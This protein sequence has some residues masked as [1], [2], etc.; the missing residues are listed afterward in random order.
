MLSLQLHN[1]PAT[2]QTWEFSDCCRFT[3]MFMDKYRIIKRLVHPIVH[4]RRIPKQMQNTGWM[5]ESSQFQSLSL[6]L[7]W[8]TKEELWRTVNS[9]M[10]V[11]LLKTPLHLPPLTSIKG[12]LKWFSVIIKEGASE[13]IETDT[14]WLSAYSTSEAPSVLDPTC[15]NS[16]CHCT[17]PAWKKPASFK[18]HGPVCNTVSQTFQ[19]RS[20]NRGSP[21]VIAV[22]SPGVILSLES[23]SRATEGMRHNAVF[24]GWVVLPITSKQKWS[25][26]CGTS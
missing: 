4:R 10:P 15:S 2:Q 17:L 19:P 13:C 3:W 11:F 20:L 7:W 6:I 8:P 25:F 26:K 1:F 14:S 23:S 21:D 12:T 24:T 5:S 9:D 18:R 16:I 22:T